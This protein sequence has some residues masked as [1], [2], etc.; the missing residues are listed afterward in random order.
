VERA[1]CFKGYS[2][3]KALPDWNIEEEVFNE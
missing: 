3:G 1:I 2:K